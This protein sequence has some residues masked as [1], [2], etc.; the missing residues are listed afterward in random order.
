MRS[1]DIVQIKGNNALV[2]PDH[3]VSMSPP[4]NYLKDESVAIFL[5]SKLF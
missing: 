1:G 4:I 5:E 3:W 2:H